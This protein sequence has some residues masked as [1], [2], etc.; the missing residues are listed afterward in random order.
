MRSQTLAWACIW[1]LLLGF[2]C[3]GAEALGQATAPAT[4]SPATG[5][6]LHDMAQLA[7]VIFTGEVVAVRAPRCER[8]LDRSARD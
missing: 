7:G 3:G 2:A 6:V 8:R 1:G 4:V 5:A